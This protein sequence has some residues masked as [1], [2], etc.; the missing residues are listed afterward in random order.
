[1]NWQRFAGSPGSFRAN[2]LQ[3]RLLAYLGVTLTLLVL[4][5]GLRQTTATLNHFWFLVGDA[6]GVALAIVIGLIALAYYQ[7]FRGRSLLFLSIGFIG[8]GIIDAIHIFQVMGLDPEHVF[9]DSF[10][11]ISWSSLAA[12]LF[13]AIMLLV[14]WRASEGRISPISASALGDRWVVAIGAIVLTFL[15]AMALLAPGVVPPNHAVAV[16]PVA[17][18]M[19]GLLYLITLVI[20]LRRGDW[21]HFPFQHWLVLSLLLAVSSQLF[22]LPLSMQTGDAL[23]LAGNGLL[24][25]SYM[26]A[27]TALLSSTSNLFRQASDEQRKERINALIS[28]S[29]PARDLDSTSSALHKGTMG[30]GTFEVDLVTGQVRGNPVAMG[31]LGG[32]IDNRVT[33][34]LEKIRELRHPDDAMKMVE[35]LRRSQVDGEPFR[36]QFRM[37]TPGGGYHWLEAVAGVE[38]VAGKPVRLLGF[39]DD[40]TARKTLEL[41]KERL[42]LELD[43]MISAVDQFAVSATLDPEGVILAANGLFCEFCGLAEEELIGRGLDTL[44]TEYT[45]VTVAGGLWQS[46]REGNTWKGYVELRDSPDPVRTANALLSPHLDDDSHI[47][48]FIF[49]G[50]DI[51]SRAAATRAL[52]ESIEKHRKSN[53]DLQMFAHIVSHDLQEPLRMVSSF[54]TLLERRY[55]GDLN[56]EAKEF[57][58]FAVE[59]S[60]RMRN[61]LDG[62]LEYSRMRSKDMVLEQ[63]NLN[64]PVADA[65]ANLA[66]LIRESGTV[67]CVAQLPDVRG[68]GSQLMQL[69][70]NLIANGIKFHRDQPPKIDIS[71]YSEGGRW[72]VEV[73]DN[74]IGI[75]P[76]HYQKI[77]QIF[78]RLHTREAYPGTGVGLAI[79]KQIMERHGGRIEVWS[80]PGQGTSFK[81]CF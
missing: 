28:Q 80:Q 69:F 12:R 23:H 54:M 24:L 81:L 31:L 17:K 2:W 64:K 33:L 3:P 63:L 21:R 61:L 18:A 5:S 74:G 71:S 14:G 46:L 38:F 45:R 78:S 26:L 52:D 30:A 40:I 32:Q 29:G 68:D 75:E 19:V 62:L 73:R 39:I 65:M 47:D 1:V 43:E 8:S 48:A 70:Q 50:I 77:F 4:L 36:Q 57:I 16:M 13:L 53:D 34:T 60:T 66:V 20:F 41:E 42:Y 11:T 7:S 9:T 27:F 6:T 67:I 25:G 15:L 72:V 35:A 59:G 79:C 37:K 55:A 44:L 51:T 49:L 10:T 22:Y 58:Q 76:A 56:T